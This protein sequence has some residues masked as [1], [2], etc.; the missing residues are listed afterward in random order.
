MIN[1]LLKL[2]RHAKCKMWK[3]WQLFHATDFQSLMYPCFLFCRI[4]GIFP[5]KINTSTFETSKQRYILST[6][7]ICTLCVC[8]LIT[9][10]EIDITRTFKYDNVP[11][12]LE[13]NCF[14]VLGCFIAVVTYISTGPRMYLLQTIMDISSKVSP[15][16]YWKLS[17]LVHAKDIFGFLFLVGQIILYFSMVNFLHKMFMLYIILLIFQV[18]MLY[19][20]C[21]CVLKAC[22]EENQ[23]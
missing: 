20:N 17:R 2:Q 1:P 7:I 13:R 12:I 16:S 8:E 5:Y 11:I 10:Y 19:M 3:K 15:D 21:V 4:L 9:L 6:I 22:F 23:R 18:D 14:Y